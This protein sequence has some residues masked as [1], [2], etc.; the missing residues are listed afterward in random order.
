VF[1]GVVHAPEP[2]Q[3]VLPTAV[4]VSVEQDPGA[5]LFSEPG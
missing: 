4:L 1:A 5:Q 3:T 2:L